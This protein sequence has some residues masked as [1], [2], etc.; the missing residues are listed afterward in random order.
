MSNLG[1]VVLYDDIYSQTQTGDG[2]RNDCFEIVFDSQNPIAFPSKNKIT[3]YSSGFWGEDIG[4]VIPST[5]VVGGV[6]RRIKVFRPIKDEMQPQY[7]I[8]F[9]KKQNG[10]PSNV[11]G[12]AGIEMVMLGNLPG[13]I[14]ILGFDDYENL[15]PNDNGCKKIPFSS[16]SVGGNIERGWV[17]WSN[18]INKNFCF[19]LF[20]S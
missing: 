1:G 18:K 11:F 20:C 3:L 7:C 12:L 13:G 9:I 19:A 6:G 5:P 2:V 10:V 8:N 17:G 15:A 14:K 16:V 4:S